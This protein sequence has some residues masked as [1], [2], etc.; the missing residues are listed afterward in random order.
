MNRDTVKKDIQKI[1]AANIL[2]EL[3]TGFG[4]TKQALDLMVNRG[5]KTVLILIPKLV[6]IKNWKDEF[7][8]WGLEDYLNR[9]T[10]STYVGIKKFEN[11]TFD[12]LIGDEAHH[13]TDKSLYYISTMTV[14]S[15]ILLSATVG[16]LIDVLKVNFSKLHCY[17]VTA[18]DAMD[19]G[20]LPD[21]RVY[22]IPYSLDN[23]DRIYPFEL[24]K[25]NK[26]TSITCSY[27]DKWE[28]LK[29]KSYTTV[30]VMCTQLEYINELSSKIDYWK[31]MYMR[32]RS[33]IYKNK[34]LFLAGQ[35][36]KMLSTFKN[37]I[38]SNLLVALKN[39]RCLT[40]CNSVEQT[41]ILGK[42]HI[43]NKNK[44]SMEVLGNFNKGNINHITSCSMLNEGVNLVDCQVGIY[45]SLNSSEI[46]IKQKLG[47]LLRHSEPVL[48]I[49]YYRGTREEE[50]LTTMLE[51]YNPEL[52]TEINSFNQIKI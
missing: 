31:R 46:M 20:V 44:S 52:V 8:Q 24:R 36:L 50:I 21:P 5:P 12:M 30:T 29:N 49:P 17:K 13:F 4:K 11:Q 48:I 14:K 33:D 32:G 25:S 34:W 7:I 40:F 43:S 3:P 37:S 39:Y 1:K 19:N 9:V 27:S 16:N 51:D 26:G 35:R 15:S 2:L 10:F 18:K 41:E 47:R 42:N 22:L 38:V 23:T 28:Y 6:L 45:A